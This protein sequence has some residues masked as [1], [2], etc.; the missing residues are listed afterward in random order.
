M[1]GWR[2]RL[3]VL[4]PS[5]IVATEAEFA[6]MAPEGVSCHYHRISF[7]GGRDDKDVV[8]ALRSVGNSVTEATQMI[9]DVQPAAV[10]L[11]GTGVSFVGGF[12]YD[13]EIIGK[14][15]QASGNNV[16]AT[17]TSSS[18]IEAFKKFG[19]KKV[20]IAM[21]YVEDVSRLAAKFVEDSGIG[22]VHLKWLGLRKMEIAQVSR[23]TLYHMAKEVDDPQADAIFISCTNLHTIEIIARLENDL[24]KP[25]ITSN[26][27]TM[28]NML[29]IAG[30]NDRLEGFGQLFTK[31]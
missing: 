8:K 12:G 13:Q 7:A 28:W 11:S 30:I 17:T 26:Q 15:R 9:C 5:G 27:A 6:R 22:I 3:G 10:C 4:V 23:E 18:V 29:R 2:A 24:G 21:P 25:V 19:I 16:P 20:S 14:I 1:Y 31:Y